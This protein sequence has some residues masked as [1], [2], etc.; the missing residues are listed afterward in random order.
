MK[1]LRRSWRWFAVLAGV[2]CLAAIPAVVGALPARARDVPPADLAAAIVGSTHPY[3]GYAEASGR[4]GLPELGDLNAAAG[5]LSNQTKVRVW[6]LEPAAWRVDLLTNTGETDVYGD[7]A[8]TWTWDSEARRV[9]RVDGTAPVRLPTAADVLPTALAQRLLAGGRAR[10]AAA[11]RRRTSR[12]PVPARRAHRARLTGVH[13]RARRHLG[14]SRHGGGHAGSCRAPHHERGRL[15]DAI[16]RGVAVGAEPRSRHL[17]PARQRAHRPP[18][19]RHRAPGGD[20]VAGDVARRAGR[21]PPGPGQ[22]GA[23][24]TYG[25]GFDVLGVVAVPGFAINQAIPSTIPL[26]DRPWGGK[27]RI[28]STSLVNAMAFEVDGIAYVLAGPVTRG[29]ARPGGDRDE[30][31]GGGMNAVVRTEGLTKAYGRLTVVDDVDLEVFPRRRVRVP[32]PERLGQDHDHPHAA[33]SRRT[34]GRPRGAAGADRCLTP[35]PPCWSRWARWSRARASTRPCP[36][37]G[38]SRCSTPPGAAA[39]RSTRRRRIAEALERVGLANVDRRPVRAYSLGMR[40][41][42][43]LAAALIRQPRLLVL[44]EP[45][46]GL[47]PQGIRE[48]RALLA[49]LAAAAPPCSC[50]AT[51]SARSS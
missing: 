5:L 31:V 8:G 24:A 50:R 37:A 10:R 3:S 51:S 23:V 18:A 40:Q 33:R 48:I 28:V 22:T 11:A 35:R 34:D 13:H 27:A 49:E 20:G 38:T 16:P 21:P 15:R 44:D 7:A 41:R 29:R 42:L 19:D 26:V 45:T 6:W 43:G 9:R 1:R 36:G 25:S 46:N 32:R 47:D 14:R 2:V 17:P 4:L 12:R 30:R 39:Q